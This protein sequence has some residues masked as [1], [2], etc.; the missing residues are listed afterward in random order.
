MADLKHEKAVEIVLNDYKKYLKQYFEE[1]GH[2]SYD[3][4]TS[5]YHLLL[6]FGYTEQELDEIE[7]EIK[8]K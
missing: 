6:Q 8:T 3:R 7:L 4:A 1:H 5:Y 2:F